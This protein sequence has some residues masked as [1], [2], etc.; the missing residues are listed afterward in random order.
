M[1]KTLVLMISLLLL[2]AGCTQ[3]QSDAYTADELKETITEAITVKLPDASYNNAIKEYYSYYLPRGVGREERDAT[4][5]LFN[6]YGNKAILNIDIA[7]IIADEYYDGSEGTTKAL[8][9]I[10][11][12]SQT[13]FVTHGIFNNNAKKGVMYRVYVKSIDD[14]MDYILMQDNYFLFASTCYKV[15]TRDMVYEMIKILRSCSIEEDKIVSVYSNVSNAERKTSI[16]S[17]FK[18]ILPESG[19]VADYIDDWKEDP[20]F[21]IIDNSQKEEEDPT[22]I[23]DNPDYNNENNDN[24][25]EFIGPESDNSENR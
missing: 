4:S 1:K 12:F 18:E 25:G 9:N 22:D 17:L 8:R 20:S 15:Q 11:I 13:E 21:V 14:S 3:Q 23:I 24:N 7:S 5:N 19:Y 10:D 2:L 16:I 6:I